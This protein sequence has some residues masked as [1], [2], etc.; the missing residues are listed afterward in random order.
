MYTVV[1][2]T[3]HM[4]FNNSVERKV[5]VV[6]KKKP[7]IKLVGDKNYYICPNTN[8]FEAGYSAYDNYDKEITEK[9]KVRYGKEKVEYIVKDSSGNESIAI[10]RIIK[11]DIVPPIITLNG[12]EEEYIFVGEHYE[13]KKIT[14]I[15]NCDGRVDDIKVENHVDYNTP[16][17][18]EIKYIA[19]DKANNKSEIIRKVIVEKRKKTLNE[20]KTIYLT[21]DDGPGEYTEEILNIL[22]EEGIKATFFIT[23][24]GSDEI[25]KRQLKEGHTIGIHTASHDYSY[26]YLNSTNFFNDFNIV[27]DR[28]IL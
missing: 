13:D 14:A 21:F 26:V 15:D 3:N 10:R 27:N 19:K 24:N 17:T 25:V 1:Y 22:K 9:V 11:E 2:T 28:Y 12:N 5:K 8:Y 16:G 7:K 20:E 6:D 4:L 18:Y 23:N